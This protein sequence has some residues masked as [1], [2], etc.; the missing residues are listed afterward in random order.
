MLSK[1]MSLWE[2]NQAL[3]MFFI[4]VIFDFTSC[5]C[6]KPLQKRK[7][8]S[9]TCMYTHT[10]THAYLN[11]H[12]FC[13]KFRLYKMFLRNTPRSGMINTAWAICC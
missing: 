1:Q 10:H 6:G 8:H 13:P 11:A 3:P 5:V 4:A 12:V 9:N 7:C 2:K